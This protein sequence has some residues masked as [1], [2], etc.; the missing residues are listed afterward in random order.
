MISSSLSSSLLR[1]RLALA[2]QLIGDQQVVVA[3]LQS[4]GEDTTSANAELDYIV[5][6]RC[7]L[8]ADLASP[9]APH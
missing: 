7:A 2:Q 1:R 4:V 6:L 9:V 3:R 5:G 8:M